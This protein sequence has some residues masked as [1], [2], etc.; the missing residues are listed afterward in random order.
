MSEGPT[1][2]PDTRRMVGPAVG[3]SLIL[4]AYLTE[5]I[6]ETVPEFDPAGNSEALTVLEDDVMVELS[7]PVTVV[8][9]L[10]RAEA[11]NPESIAERSHSGSTF[12][13]AAQR[14]K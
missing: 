13:A 9:G 1:F 11:Q 7:L 12:S 3:P 14:S 4:D 5:R 2:N 10:L 8:R 6:L